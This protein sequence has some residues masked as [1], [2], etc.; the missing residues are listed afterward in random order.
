MLLPNLGSQQ[1]SLPI[2]LRGAE[3]KRMKQSDAIWVMPFPDPSWRLTLAGVLHW[4]GGRKTRSVSEALKI[5]P[6]YYDLGGGE[7]VV[8]IIIVSLNEVTLLQT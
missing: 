2:V 1:Q 7:P 5:I 6:F 4:R 3:R 8:I